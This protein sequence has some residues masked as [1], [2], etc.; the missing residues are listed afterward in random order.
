MAARNSNQ[1]SES[2]CYFCFRVK[3][4]LIRKR[5][6]PPMNP[7]KL[8]EATGRKMSHFQMNNGFV[9]AGRE[10]ESQ[11]C[12]VTHSKCPCVNVCVCV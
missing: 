11:K 2:T 8:P 4:A 10:E 3:P 6:P 7:T 1:A 5:T 9:S 12:T